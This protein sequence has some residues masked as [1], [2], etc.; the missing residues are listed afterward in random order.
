MTTPAKRMHCEGPDGPFCDEMTKNLPL[1]YSER[2]YTFGLVGVPSYRPDRG[3]YDRVGLRGR[4]HENAYIVPFCP[5]CGKALDTYSLQAETAAAEELRA[6]REELAAL[7]TQ[8]APDAVT[9]LQ[10]EVARLDTALRD[11]CFRHA[12]ERQRNAERSAETHRAEKEAQRLRSELSTVRDEAN[13]L[14][15]RLAEAHRQLDTTR[16]EPRPPSDAHQLASDEIAAM[17]ARALAAPEGPYHDD[18]YRIYGPTAHEDKRNG[19][20]LLDYKHTL[21]DSA[22]RL[23]DLIA[24]ARTDILALVAEV[25]RQ[26]AAIHR[27]RVALQTHKIEELHMTLQAVRDERDGYRENARLTF[28]NAT[29][30]IETLRALLRGRNEAPTD[31][32]FAAHPHRWRAMGFGV[33]DDRMTAR[34]AAAVRDNDRAAGISRR[35]WCLGPDDEVTAFP[36]LTTPTET[37]TP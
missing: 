7:R 23:P 34:M 20:V 27:L 9:Q 8:H 31:R 1:S 33:Y 2:E 12:A 10:H 11:E 14:H 28:K 17:E 35:W 13:D 22:T 15:V 29:H 24:H 21:S 37:P 25:R 6:L 30:E 3:F 36:D 18:G 5:F 19:E 4:A 16:A 26:D 32:E